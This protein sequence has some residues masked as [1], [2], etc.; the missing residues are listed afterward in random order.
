VLLC[1]VIGRV[2]SDRRAPELAGRRLD[3]LE[4]VDRR[5]VA[6]GRRYVAVDELGAAEGQLVLT[7]A[8]ASARL[9][10]DLADVPVDL[11][12]V[13]VLDAPPACLEGE[14]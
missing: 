13:A 8:A 3:L 1:R 6:T 9:A 14:P 5:L 11:A 4:T 2:S 10:A 7:A 12:V